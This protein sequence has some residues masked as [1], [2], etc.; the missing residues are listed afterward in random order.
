SVSVL[1]LKLVSP[2]Y[3]AVSVLDP[4]VVSV[5]LQVPV[6]PLS[7]PVHVSP[8]TS[9]TVIVTV[10]VGVGA[11]PTLLVTLKLIGT[12]CPTI[13]GSGVSAVISVVVSFFAELK[14]QGEN[15]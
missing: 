2:L 13:E 8:L 9:L 12:A 14:V 4:T 1:V 3:M 11:P 10:P 7:G 6:P 5:K 15:C